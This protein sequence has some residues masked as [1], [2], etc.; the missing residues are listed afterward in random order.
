MKQLV[1]FAAAAIVLASCTP[2]AQVSGCFAGTKAIAYGFQSD[3]DTCIEIMEE[4][5]D[6]KDGKFA[7]NVSDEPGE[8]F[9]ADKDDFITF[10]QIYLAQGEKLVMEGT[11]ADYKISGT[12]FYQDMGEY[13]ELVKEFDVREREAIMAMAEN[14]SEDEEEEIDD[15]ASED[16]AR[17]KQECDQAKS[18]IGLAFVKAHPD[19]DFSAYLVCYLRKS[20]FNEGL[21]ALTERARN[22]K[23]KYLID[24]TV[25][26]YS[27]DE[28]SMKAY[29]ESK[30]KVYVGA[31]APDFTLK[32]IDGKDFTLSSLRGRY[33]MLDFWGSWCH[34]CV[35]G[36]PK[37]KEISEKY[38]DKL[39]VVSVDCND[40]EARWRKAVEK[41][42]YMTWPQVYNPRSVSIDGT[43]QV[44]AFPTFIIINP[45][46]KIIAKFEGESEHF[47]AEV[48][49]LIE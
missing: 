48:G 4:Y 10:I 3:N 20:D 5:S 17:V 39:T 29:A 36:M 21:Q 43:Y 27:G 8:L 46:G 7:F 23:L 26:R 30:G 19:S 24:K 41:I 31:D 22:G 32:T 47:V 9:I 13:H 6:F 18:E 38:A 40:T 37:V 11:M 15:A 42:G 35:E 44:E 12:P 49:K 45:E 33:V 28:A 14:E 2:K 34:W 1:L 25:Q 16:Y